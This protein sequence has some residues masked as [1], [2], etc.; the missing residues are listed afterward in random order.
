MKAEFQSASVYIAALLLAMAF[1]AARAEIAFQQFPLGFPYSTGRTP[2]N[3][4]L[5]GSDGTLYGVTSEGGTH[6]RGTVFKIKEDGSAFGILHHFGN[7]ANDGAG[8]NCDLVFGRDGALYGTTLTGGVNGLGTI[9]RIRR[10]GTSY[11]ALFHF[12]SSTGSNPRGGRLEEGGDGAW[13]G[14]TQFGPSG[15]IYKINQDGTGF[16]V[17]YR[18]GG[19]SGSAPE[20][21]VTLGSD[22]MLYGVASSGGQYNQGTM[23]KIGQDGSGFSVLHHFQ[24]PAAGDG[25]E[26]DGQLLELADGRLYGTTSG[27]GLAPPGTIYRIKPSGSD[28]TLLRMFNT[29]NGEPGAITAG[30]IQGTDGALYS[31]SSAEVFKIQPDGSGLQVLHRLSTSPPESASGYRARGLVLGTSGALFGTTS[32]R[33]IGFPG[34]GTIFR[35]NQD[36]TDFSVLYRFQHSTNYMRLPRA[37]L[38]PGTDGLFYGTTEMGGIGTNATNG[39]IFSVR[40]N[41][42]DIRIL[43]VFGQGTNTAR[44]PNGLFQG[45]DGW[46]YGTTQAGG[47]SNAGVVFKIAT[48][49][50]NYGI[51]RHM[52]RPSE[53]YMPLGR[54]TEGS[55]GWLYGTSVGGGANGRGTVF[56]IQ[57]DSGDFA[58]V[59]HFGA[60]TANGVSPYGDLVQG[61]GAL[62]GTASQGGAFNLGTIYRVYGD[63]SGF[64]I[65]HSFT[66]GNAGQNP[67]SGLMIG[68]D[69]RLYGTTP[70]IVGNFAGV[71]FSVSMSG[72]DYQVLRAFPNTGTE[73]KGPKAPLVEGTDGF[74]YGSTLSGGTH[75]RG[76]LFRIG[77]DGS[78]FN[79]LRH[80]G[81][82]FNDGQT[83]S[84]SLAVVGD[85]SFLGLTE[86]GGGGTGTLFKFD[87][88]E[89]RLR[90][91]LSGS[92]ADLTWNRSSTADTLE[93]ATDLGAPDWQPFAG[94]IAEEAHQYR[95]LLQLDFPA[96]FFRV[97][98]VWE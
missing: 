47:A 59:R 32:L 84:A 56:R 90:V 39:T 35:I 80:F 55:A 95:T 29:T 8:P 73:P 28:Y 70:R 79:V 16:Q 44:I 51:L 14:T 96:R 83:P 93:T 40:S 52:G 6:G 71:L 68:S 27:S 54:L 11:Q 19:T 34:D 87:P 2:Q 45:S 77:R 24:G 4:L 50:S 92:H 81:P 78:S 26:P 48:T 97:R 43:F 49:G 64:T 38:I 66:G 58:V 94:V 67:Q 7:V 20:T 72:T 37:P 23:F 75:N 98:R 3:R 74:L 31:T 91:A 22:G 12:T 5:S 33:G 88:E 13:Y 62:Y 21:G 9:F 76:T 1:P 30:L 82:A 61:D 41:G 60:V 57:K 53:P 42:T 89:A 86:A 25:R 10:D 69:Q 46:L 15:T 18:L 63:G 36:G 17:L 65:L 85:G